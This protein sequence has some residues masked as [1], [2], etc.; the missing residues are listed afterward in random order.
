MCVILNNK[1]SGV[2][3]R[4]IKT[5]LQNKNNTDTCFRRKTERKEILRSKVE[6]TRHKRFATGPEPEVTSRF[7]SINQFDRT[8]ENDSGDTG[9]S[10]KV[11]YYITHTDTLKRQ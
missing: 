1:T 6:V 3:V 4:K 8:E 2:V 11:I 5:K 10:F 9:G 7:R